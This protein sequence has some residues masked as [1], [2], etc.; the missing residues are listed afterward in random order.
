L[1]IKFKKLKLI[2]CYKKTNNIYKRMSQQQDVATTALLRSI[3]NS[4]NFWF[5]ATFVPIGIISNLIVIV[6]FARSN[7][8]QTS[9]MSLFYISLAIYDIFA[10][11]N[12]I[13]FIQMLPSFG[14][15]IGNLSDFLCK[16]SFI[17]RRTTIQSPSLI[18]TIL[19]FDRFRVVVMPRKLTFM[20]NKK[21]TASLILSVFILLGLINLDHLGYYLNQV[22]INIINHAHT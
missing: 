17:Y 6:V 12:S 4:I 14:I 16:M 18:Q 1:F 15:N 3:S 10:L 9:N 19:T 7:L 2:F 21:I 5:S 11:S 22:R 20:D 8:R 13:L